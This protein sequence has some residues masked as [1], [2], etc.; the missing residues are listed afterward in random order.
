MSS[1]I[2]SGWIFPLLPMGTPMTMPGRLWSLKYNKDLFYPDLFAFDKQMIH[3]ATQ[4]D[5]FSNE[6]LHLLHIHEDDKIIA[7]QRSGLIFIFNFH[8][9]H[10]FSDYPVAAPPGKYQML[11]NT[12][13][14]QFG[15]QQRLTP[16]QIHFTCPGGEAVDTHALSLYLP[17]R[18]AIILAFAD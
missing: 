4:R 2:P 9:S 18:C 16:E 6:G 8:P 11:L 14:Q 3:L 10:S 13:E 12:D 7:F 1:A 5:L 15:G 17:S